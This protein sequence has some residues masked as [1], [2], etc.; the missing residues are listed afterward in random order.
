MTA[1]CSGHGTG[2]SMSAGR[3]GRWADPAGWRALGAE[4]ARASRIPA[5]FAASF[6]LGFWCEWRP[7][8]MK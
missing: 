1:E 8:P 2:S 4:L 6:T 3:P 5:R 7:S